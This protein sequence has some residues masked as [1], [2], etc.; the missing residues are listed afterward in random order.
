MAFVVRLF[1]TFR[2]FQNFVWLCLCLNADLSRLNVFVGRLHSILMSPKYFDVQYEDSVGPAFWRYPAPSANDSRLM[3]VS[4]HKS[5]R[6]K[7]QKEQRTW[8]CFCN[9]KWKSHVRTEGF[10][11]VGCRKS[12]SKHRFSTFCSINRGRRMKSKQVPNFRQTSYPVDPGDR[13][14]C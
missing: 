14:P 6:N 7:Q 4:G 1:Q 2:G 12:R 8:F 5:M 11:R 3:S 9:A 13:H 10:C